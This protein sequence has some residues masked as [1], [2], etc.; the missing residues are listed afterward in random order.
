[1]IDP[2]TRVRR[3]KYP[4]DQVLEILRNKQK[5]QPGTIFF[6]KVWARIC[7]SIRYKSY[8]YSGV[9]CVL[10]GLEGRYFALERQLTSGNPPKGLPPAAKWPIYWF[11]LY[12]TDNDKEVLMTADHIVPRCLGGT[13]ETSN[14]QTLCWKCNN[15]KSREDNQAFRKSLEAIGLELPRIS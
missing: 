12:G 15:I 2:L 3:G 13:N 5:N 7:S 1:M 14:L 11:N 9:N 8:V 4:I 6:G 10:C